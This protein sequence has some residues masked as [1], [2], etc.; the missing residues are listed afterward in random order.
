MQ[1]ATGSY[2]G[3]GS[4]NRSITGIGFQ[5]DVIW[6]KSAAGDP[7]VIRTSTMAGDAAKVVNSTG[8]LQTDRIQSLDANGFTIGTN[9]DV[10]A[11]GVTYYWV[12]MKAGAELKL[13]TY[14]GDGAD[15]RNITG[16]GFTP[17]WVITLGDGDDSAFR[18]GPLAGDASSLMSGT[19]NLTNR[20][21][22]LQAGGFQIGSN[23]DVN[24]TGTTFHYIAWAS[25]SNAAA[26][27]YT[28]DGNDNRS[29]SG[30]GFAPEVVWVKRDNAQQSS[31]RPASAIG[32]TS[33]F[34]N[35]TAN[36]SNCIQA[37][38]A[39]GFQAG[40]DAQVNTNNQ[41]YYYLALKDGP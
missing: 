25:S 23:T 41:S 17:I 6:I 2:T 27:S 22:A 1:L 14:A 20:I 15:N 11:T 35:A 3:N 12:A 31:W 7:G 13:G 40:K 37:L 39:D 21:Q 9:S 30:V 29:I 36:A 33:L 10:N 38:E 24:E 8:A 18:P 16:V 34:W 19:A 32:D 5:P 4:D 26:G 28:G